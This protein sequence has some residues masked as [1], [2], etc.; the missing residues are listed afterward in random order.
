MSRFVPGNQITLLQNGE[1]YF[2]AIEHAFDQA[3]HE[4]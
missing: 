4:I 1:A 2:T 3:Q